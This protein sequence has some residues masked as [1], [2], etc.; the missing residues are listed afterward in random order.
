MLKDGKC[1]RALS[2]CPRD[3]SLA[4]TYLLSTLVA[5]QGDEGLWFCGHG[6]LV[7]DYL[8]DIE[9]FQGVGRWDRAGAQDDIVTRQLIRT[10]LCQP[11]FVP[12]VD[13]ENTRLCT[14]ETPP[15]SS[16]RNQAEAVLSQMIMALPPSPG[17]AGA[18]RKGLCMDTLGNVLCPEFNRTGG[19][20]EGFKGHTGRTGILV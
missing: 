10:T 8:P 5:D 13:A 15:D 1:L 6:T 18:P 11:T 12:S 17:W 3:T 7:D 16:P 19:L 20:G 2:S 9:L 14:R 4:G